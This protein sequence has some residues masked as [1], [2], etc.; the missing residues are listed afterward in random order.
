M[1]GT[2][3]YIHYFIRVGNTDAKKV[4]DADDDYDADGAN[5]DVGDCD[6]T[7]KTCLFVFD[8]I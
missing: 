2:K 7:G 5:D 6:D 1:S 3:R 4:V 8:L